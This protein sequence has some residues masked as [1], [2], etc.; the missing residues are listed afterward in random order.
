MVLVTAELLGLTQRL[1]SWD[2]IVTDIVLHHGKTPRATV[3][4]QLRSY[5]SVPGNSEN[6]QVNFKMNS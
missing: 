4:G 2:K 5:S 3:C 1:L 6:T